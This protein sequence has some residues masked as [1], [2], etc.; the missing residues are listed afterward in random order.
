MKSGIT[1]WK[2]VPEYRDLPV[3]LSPVFGLV[4]S[5]V[6]LA[7]PTKLATVFGAALGNSST[8]ISPLLV[9]KIAVMLSETFAADEGEAAG[10]IDGVVVVSTIVGLFITSN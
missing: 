6:P 2:I 9:L 7:K 4:H 5:L 10:V 3:I 8:V 1:L